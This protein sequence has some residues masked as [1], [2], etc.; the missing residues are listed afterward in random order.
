MCSSGT[1][2]CMAEVRSACRIRHVEG[3]ALTVLELT[4][5]DEVA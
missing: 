5:C 4:A 1:S 2:D 3:Q